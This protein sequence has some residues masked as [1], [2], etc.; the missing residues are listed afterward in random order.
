MQEYFS[1]PFE[2]FN[3]ALCLLTRSIQLAPRIGQAALSQ[4]KAA[5]YYQSGIL[6]YTAAEYIC[7]ARLLH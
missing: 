4:A 6:R 3:A 2:I 1:A 5:Q 7:L